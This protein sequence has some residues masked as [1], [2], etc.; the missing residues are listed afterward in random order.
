MRKEELIKMI[1]LLKKVLFVKKREHES[2]CGGLRLL[3]WGRGVFYLEKCSEDD[4]HRSALGLK[5]KC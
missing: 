1:D 4:G 2:E 5:V 3:C